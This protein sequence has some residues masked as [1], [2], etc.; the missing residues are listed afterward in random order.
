MAFAAAN[1]CIFSV[2]VAISSPCTCY[3]QPRTLGTAIGRQWNG[4]NIQEP[5]V[6]EEALDILL[7]KAHPDVPHLL[8]IVFAI[9]RQH[10]D[11]DHTPA[12]LDDARDL[13]Q[14]APRLRQVMQHQHQ[15]R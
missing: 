14:R 7:R 3:E 13:S 11:D 1:G 12:W 5:S 15:R 10:V 6:R 4:P 8:L 9:V 2:T